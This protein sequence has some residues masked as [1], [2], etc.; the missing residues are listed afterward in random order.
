MLV[1]S[2]TLEIGCGTDRRTLPTAESWDSLPRLERIARDYAKQHAVAF[3][4]AGTHPESRIDPW[5][6]NLAEIDFYHGM[7]QPVFGAKID[8]GGSVVDSW[9]STL[10]DASKFSDFSDTSKP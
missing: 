5:H 10:M 6:T 4:F 8:R 3:D 2:A 9:I 1:A 7:N